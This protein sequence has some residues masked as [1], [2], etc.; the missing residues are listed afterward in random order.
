M[1]I[2]NFQ[3]NPFKFTLSYSEQN[4]FIRLS[5]GRSDQSSQVGLGGRGAVGWR[6]WSAGQVGQDGQSGQIGQGGQ[7][8]RGGHGRQR[9]DGVGRRMG[10]SVR[11]GRVVSLGNMNSE[12]IRFMWSF[13]KPLIKVEISHQ[14]S[15]TQIY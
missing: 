8:G 2:H 9:L 4:I 14:F 7:G 11:V 6:G 15:G 1:N 3:L 10:S 5:G 12:N 13:T